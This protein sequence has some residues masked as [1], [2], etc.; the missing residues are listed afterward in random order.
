MTILGLTSHRSSSVMPLRSQVPP[1][2]CLHE[3]VGVFDDF[4]ESL[5]APFGEVVDR[6]GTLVAALGLRLTFAVSRMVSPAPVF[7]RAR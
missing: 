5:L 1:F 7:P 4:E 6:D 2:G 3:D